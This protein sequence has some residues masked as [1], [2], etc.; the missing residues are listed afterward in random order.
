[1]WLGIDTGTGGTRAL[2]TAGD[3]KV[4]AAFTA[5]HEDVRMERPL[6][7]EQRP[8]DWWRAAIEAIRGVLGAAGVPGRDVRGVGLSGQMHGL[9][10][11]DQAGEVIRPALIWCD[12]R[13]QP[14]VDQINRTVGKENVLAA[15]ANPVLTGFTLPK[16][17]WVRE[18]DPGSYERVSRILLPKD[19]VRYRLTGGFATD[20]S[21]ASG[22]ALFDVARRRWSLDMMDRLG[23]DRGILPECFES[24][25]VTGVISAG[26]A[27]ITG[28][29]AGTPVAG[30]G[31]DQAA[32][33]VGNGIVEPGIVSCTLGTSGVVFAHMEN[34]AYDAPG[35]V[36]TFCHAVRDKWHVMGVT[37]GAGLSLQ[38]FRNQLSGPGTNYDGL[39]AEAANAPAGSEGLF[40]LPYLM[41]ERTPH[42]DATARGG[43][44]GMTARHTRAH[45]IRSLIEG[46]SYSQRDCLDIIEQLGVRVASVRLSGGGAR[47]AFWRG[48]L[49][50]I[51]GKPV[52]TLETQEGSAY[53]ASLLA[54]VATGEFASVKDV[55]RAAVREVETSEPDAARSREYGERHAVYQSLY[56]ALKPFF[57]R[58]AGM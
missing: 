31:G 1:M 49:A 25:E 21:D 23:L 19:Y 51:L 53:G 30:G 7:A 12:Q 11:L 27:E 40:W 5:A 55:C 41:G 28:L 45:L 44:I 15:I 32:S 10:M 57:G 56:P 24:A 36:H 29:R 13:S 33:A 43:W 37:Q 52:V 54:M 48:L 22:T 47:S 18:H 6:W 46:V 2:L 9:T 20:V 17:L 16:L 8:E 58:A 26:A 50:D 38:W 34:V 4:R 35:R 3:G 42:L 14:Q 39:T